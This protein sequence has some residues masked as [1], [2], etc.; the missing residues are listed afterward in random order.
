MM[1]SIKFRKSEE[2]PNEDRTQTSREG[3]PDCKGGGTTTLALAGVGETA[4]CIQLPLHERGAVALAKKHC[5]L[6]LT[7]AGSKQA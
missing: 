5:W 4:N 1:E 3:P 2:G 6:L 7:G